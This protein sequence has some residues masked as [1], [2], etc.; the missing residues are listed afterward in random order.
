MTD[1]ATLEGWGVRLER[2]EA[3]RIV[4]RVWDRDVSVWGG[5]AATPEL[6]D[7]LGWLDLPG[8]MAGR[9][10]EFTTFAEW[11]RARFDRV[12]LCGM[13]GSSLAPE[14]LWRTFGPRAGYPSLHLLD[15]THPDA[16]AAAAPDAALARTLILIASKSGT[17]IETASFDR[18][19]W[20]RTGGNGAQ[21]VAITDPGTTLARSA[22]D[23]G[24][25]RVFESPPDVGG[26]FSALSPFGLVPAALIGVDL[27]RFVARAA[28]EADALRRPARDNR[29]AMLGALMGDDTTLTL[30]MGGALGALG[31]WVEQLVAESTGKR[32]RGVL[33]VYG[34][35][36]AAF[37]GREA[38]RVW[39]ARTLGPVPAELADAL[40]R[41]RGGGA[42]LDQHPLDDPYDLAAEFLR[43]EFATAV[44]GAL[45][46]VNP[47]DQPNVAESKAHTSRVLASGA[48]PSAADDPAAL[49]R[50][51]TGVR[52]GDYVAVMAYLPAGTEADTRLRRL[53]SRLGARLGVPVTVGYGPRFL[54]STG[55]FHK[56]GPPRGHFVQIV[57]R[58]SRDLPIPGVAYG[59][60]RLIAAQAEGDLEAIRSRG[61]PAVRVDDWGTLEG[62]VG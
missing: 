48:P 27:A 39:V 31:L 44:A 56:G 24:F 49:E 11:V 50:W 37:T 5:D 25:A 7:R 42:T 52:P 51:L 46:G 3:E 6:S 53:Q 54:H 57:D 20:E 58:P 62:V 4:Q 29:G 15:S 59:F 28:R 13:G 14:V 22:A 40:G 10:E 8:T 35:P 23:R 32:G 60:A 21:F 61:R 1:G 12:L 17:T 19:F 26:R 47:F 36:L 38:G 18:H 34:E 33:P 30:L 41:L 45:L 9:A 2:V 16:V 43:F 55:Q